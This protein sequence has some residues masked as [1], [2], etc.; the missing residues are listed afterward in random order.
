LLIDEIDKSDINLPN[1]LLN[2]FE[3]GSFIIP[4][5]KRLAKQGKKTQTVTTDDDLE[6]E[7]SEGKVQCSAF[8][9]VVMT[10]NGERDFPPAFLRRCLRVKMP[11]PNE[12]DLQEIV[13]AHLEDEKLY[14]K[15][16]VLINKYIKNFVE[17][18]D[19]SELGTI[20]TDQLLN[21]IHLLTHEA[22]EK[23]VD[24]L[25]DVLLKPLTSL[26]DSP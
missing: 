23:D 4:E 5:L 8:P 10:S 20:A 1:D 3:E 24:E 22:D 14:D 17:R 2:L 9:L 11:D 15:F 19:E 6:V 21:T 26:E 12:G 13:K 7:V 16:K 25:E 18:R